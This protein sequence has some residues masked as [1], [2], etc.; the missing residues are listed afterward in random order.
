MG[1]WKRAG[2]RFSEGARQEPPSR[3]DQAPASRLAPSAAGGH[4]AGGR[5]HGWPE[6]RELKPEAPGVEDQDPPP[7]WWESYDWDYHSF[8]NCERGDCASCNTQATWWAQLNPCLPFEEDGMVHI[9]NADDYAAMCG[10][11]FLKKRFD[12]TDQAFIFAEVARNQHKAITCM[13]CMVALV[14]TAPCEP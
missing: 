14:R 12:S 10:N 9:T 1:E 2:L 11:T 4:A 8:C 13:E 3:A 5:R 6:R 7:E